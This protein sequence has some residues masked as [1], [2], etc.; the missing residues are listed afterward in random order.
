MKDIK[1]FEDKY[2]DKFEI[3]KGKPCNANWK[4]E[5]HGGVL[6]MVSC[7]TCGTILQSDCTPKCLKSA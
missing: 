5:T 7:R 3:S 4:V 1:K 6:H 2:K